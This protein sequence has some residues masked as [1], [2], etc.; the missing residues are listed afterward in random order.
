MGGH[1]RRKSPLIRLDNTVAKS[2]PP[3]WE[4]PSQLG[5]LGQTGIKATLCPQEGKGAGGGE[6]WLCWSHKAPFSLGPGCPGQAGWA[7]QQP[8]PPQAW[9][10]LLLAC[11]GWMAG[12]AELP[13]HIV[14]APKSP[15]VDLVC[16]EPCHCTQCHMEHPS[17][18]P[19]E[20]AVHPRSPARSLG[21]PEETRPTC[22]LLFASLSREDVDRNSPHY[23]QEAELPVR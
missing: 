6:R 13:G 1:V 2:W 14:G 20:R 11:N 21:R 12:L 22:H 7:L 18:C 5:A 4:T 16:L 23:R 8:H 15:S 19:G 10:P 3:Y 9:E 17:L